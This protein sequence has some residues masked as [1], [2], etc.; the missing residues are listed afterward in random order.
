MADS[1][2][3]LPSGRRGWTRAGFSSTRCYAF[4]T[5]AAVTE[6]RANAWHAT[7]QK[8]STI[9]DQALASSPL[10]QGGLLRSTDNHVYLAHDHTGNGVV[11]HHDGQYWLSY[12]ED[13]ECTIEEAKRRFTPGFLRTSC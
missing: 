1:R 4:V 13:S 7:R 2:F 11:S 10:Q 5:K 8:D 9:F 3:S 6:S 12:G